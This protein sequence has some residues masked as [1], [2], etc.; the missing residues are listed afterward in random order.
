MVGAGR[1]GRHHVVGLLSEDAEMPITVCDIDKEQLKR[2]DE[3]IDDVFDNLKFRTLDEVQESHIKYA[4]AIIA[5]TANNRLAT[6]EML[7]NKEVKNLLIEKPVE[8]SLE[9]VIK[10]IE[11]VKHHNAKAFVNLVFRTLEQFRDF[12]VM[13]NDPELFG[14]MKNFNLIGGSIGIAC[15]GVHYLDII[16]KMTGADDYS[17]NEASIDDELI[18]SPRG[19]EFFDF[20]G[21]A[22]ID[23]LRSGKKVAELFIDLSA[24]SSALPVLEIT[25]DKAKLAIHYKKREYTLVKRIMTKNDQKDAANKYTPIEFFD[26]KKFKITSG[27]LNWLNSFKGERVDL[28]K[29]EENLLVNRLIF[30]WL[31]SSSKYQ[32]TF[33]I[34]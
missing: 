15:N 16:L 11:L 3:S 5:S 27:T 9:N 12:E 21:R 17:L 32:N 20:G 8:Q 14:A 19:T 29:L 10:A 33:P 30:E 26:F 13:I 22:S 23:L 25:G 18:A 1:M 24:T 31:S 28:P 34:T 6:I 2:L 7:L 4:G